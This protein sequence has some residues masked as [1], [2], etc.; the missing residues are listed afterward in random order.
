MCSKH[1]DQ[2][3]NKMNTLAFVNFSLIKIFHHQNFAP[4]VI[5]LKVETQSTFLFS[6]DCILIVKLTTKIAV[7]VYKSSLQNTTIT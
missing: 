3:D 2:D 1:D 6:F 4:Y 7:L 5:N